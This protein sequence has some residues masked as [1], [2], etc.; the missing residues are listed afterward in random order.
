VRFYH[1]FIAIILYF[2][3][4]LFCQKPYRGAEYRTIDEFLYGRFEVKMK[5]AIGSGVVSSFFT[6]D[7][8]WANG[9][10]STSNW[11][12]IDFEALGNISNAIQTNIITAYETHHE[13]LIYTPF[14]PYNSFHIYAFE[15]TPLSIK[16]FIDDQLVRQDYNDYVSTHNTAQKIMMNIWQ[17]IWENWVGEFDESILPV[18]AFYDWVKYYSYTP[19]EGTYGSFNNFTFDWEDEFEFYNDQIW[20]KAT[21]TWSANNAQFVQQNAVLQDGF[22][23]LCL[24]D[25]FSYGYSGG[26]LSVSESFLNEKKIG[27]KISPN[28]FNSSFAIIIPKNLEN[29]V[30]DIIFYDIKGNEVL[31]NKVNLNGKTHINFSKANLS[32]GLYFLKI[33]SGHDEYYSKITY[34]R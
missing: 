11:R 14:Y 21:H 18:Y 15:W 20:Q 27:F 31:R 33:I 9:Q 12:E 32:T 25:N 29:K 22:L 23:I 34:L 30:S 2:L 6:I 10:S 26:E 3:N 19:G 16:F 13:E 1:F 24:T 7:D 8:Y 28:P 4:F 5:T 17:P